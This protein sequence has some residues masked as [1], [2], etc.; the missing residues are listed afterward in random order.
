M[1]V[2][3]AGAASSEM[4]VQSD[5]HQF[6]RDIL[7]LDLSPSLNM[8]HR[9]V[10]GGEFYADHVLPHSTASA[11]SLP[12][13]DSGMSIEA[14]SYGGQ[15]CQTTNE[16]GPMSGFP[17][18]DLVNVPPMTPAPLTMFNSSE[19]PVSMAATTLSSYVPQHELLSEESV[20][21]PRQPSDPVQASLT[22]NLA[23][24]VLGDLECT[25]GTL[26]QTPS[27]Q[28]LGLQDL[29]SSVSNLIARRLMRTY[30]PSP[31]SPWWLDQYQG[32]LHCPYNTT[33]LAYF[34]NE[35]C[36]GIDLE[37]LIRTHRPPF[38]NGTT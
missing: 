35:L 4:R 37:C 23:S 36:I 15:L 16:T 17:A 29:I 7:P 8:M 27:T 32:A 34:H 24:N 30:S 19:W 12:F 6:S 13:A 25:Q 22:Q 18:W 14:P 38:Y 20:E 5:P 21:T 9:P 2:N 10:S 3:A 26:V 33:I 11:S 31:S 1:I 28:T